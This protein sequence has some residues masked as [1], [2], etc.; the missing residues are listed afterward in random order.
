MF[1]CLK[2][3]ALICGIKNEKYKNRN[4]MNG[5]L[6]N[7]GL[8]MIILGAIILCLSYALNWVDYNWVDGTALLVMILGLI[9]HIIMNKR[10]QE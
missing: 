4:T 6:K 2:N 10:I 7:L 3:Y 5:F 9:V 1:L 8:I